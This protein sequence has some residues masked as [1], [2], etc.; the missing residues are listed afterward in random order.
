[1]KKRQ[2]SNSKTK[3]LATSREF[4]DGEKDVDCLSTSAPYFKF[5]LP[6]YNFFALIQSLLLLHGVRQPH[7]FNHARIWIAPA[8]GLHGRLLM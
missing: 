5:S 3:P 4:L 2:L 1:M 7:Q 8:M 6:W